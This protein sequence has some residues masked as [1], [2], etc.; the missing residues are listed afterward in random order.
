MRSGHESCEIHRNNIGRLCSC[1]GSDAATA[2][3]G[4]LL[5]I[6]MPVYNVLADWELIAKV[7][8]LVTLKTQLLFLVTLRIGKL[9]IH[10]VTMLMWED[11]L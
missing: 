1:H 7:E 6:S 11:E 8:D 2:A 3:N 9:V 4:R 10:E 5:L